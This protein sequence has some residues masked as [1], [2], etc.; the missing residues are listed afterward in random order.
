MI[1]M[2]VKASHREYGFN[3]LSRMASTLDKEYPKISG[4]HCELDLWRK[5][6]KESINGVVYIAGTRKNG[7][8]MDNTR[9]C[10]YCTAILYQAH[11]K[12][13]VYFHNGKPV[14]AKIQE[15]V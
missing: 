3:R 2:S 5:A 6:G 15:M 9:P 7:R 13:V 11:V 8:S 12:W 4:L 10:K 14:K 1:A